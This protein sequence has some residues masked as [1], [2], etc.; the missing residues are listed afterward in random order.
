MLFAGLL[1]HWGH[2]GPAEIPA[3]RDFT[4]KQ[5]A[6]RA[7]R[8]GVDVRGPKTH[9]FRPLTA[10]RVALPEVAGPHQEAVINALFTAIWSEGIE[11]ADPSE[12]QG[13]L[14]RAGLDGA[15][16]IGRTADPE[17]KRALLAS[18][19]AAIAQGHWGVP[20]IDADGELFWGHDSLPELEAWL[21]GEDPTRVG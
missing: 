15:A 7:A 3:K 4:F 8:L 11:A 9:P 2:K 21:R 20:T 10:L 19:E 18:T 12:L 6:R 16:L 1:K 14:D 5:I 13:A 17:V